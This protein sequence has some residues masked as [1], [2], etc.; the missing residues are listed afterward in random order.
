MS[1]KGWGGKVASPLSIGRAVDP[2]PL[3]DR[4]I[5]CSET[6]HSQGRTTY[7]SSF[8]SKDIIGNKDISHCSTYPS[9]RYVTYNHS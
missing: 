7:Y 5:Q 4:T 6:V 3:T 1:V 2:N 8:Y 9:R